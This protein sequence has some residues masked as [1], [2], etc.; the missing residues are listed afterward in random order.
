MGITS[1]SYVVAPNG[2]LWNTIK[3]PLTLKGWQT[4]SEDDVALTN[5]VLEER[6]RI[7]QVLQ[8][9]WDEGLIYRIALTLESES[10]YLQEKLAKF[11]RANEEQSTS[12]VGS[13]A[14][15]VET[16]DVSGASKA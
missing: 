1:R 5:F 16:A 14:G 3:V 8:G 6:Y 7:A 11:M 4:G 2:A 15:T 9:S 10:S 12:S 13:D